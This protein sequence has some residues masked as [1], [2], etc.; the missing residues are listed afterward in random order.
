MTSRLG[1][2]WRSH[3]GSFAAALVLGIAASCAGINS[4]TNSFATLDE[5]RRTG[6]IA[7][8]WIPAGRPPGSHDIRE[9][10]VPGTP[11][12]WG[13][14]N[15]PQAEADTLR[16]ILREEMSLQGQR[17]DM[18]KR[19]EWWPIEMRGELNGNRLAVTGIRGYRAK[20]GDLVFAVNWNQG[21][22]YYWL[23]GEP[24]STR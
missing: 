21:R 19:I 8:G 7:K 20:T 11:R 16:A 14:I 10:H 22:A 18:P 1:G 12:R 23:A 6:A 4:Q 17:C 24:A 5:A 9:A 13:I 2:R 3:V 15:F